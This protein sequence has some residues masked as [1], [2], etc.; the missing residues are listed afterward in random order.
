MLSSVR[1]FFNYAAYTSLHNNRQATENWLS[2]YNTTEDTWKCIHT[3]YNIR[4]F[5]ERAKRSLLMVTVLF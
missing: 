5:K 3:E 1:L 4:T 2:R